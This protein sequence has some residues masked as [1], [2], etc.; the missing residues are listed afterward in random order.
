M[1]VLEPGQ[2]LGSYEVERLVGR[3]GMAEVYRATHVVLERQVAIKVLNRALNTDP[4]FPI[5]FLREAKAVAKLNHPHIVTI[6]DF[7][8]KGDLA[9]LVMELAEGGTLRE[10]AAHFTTLKDAIDSLLP[11][12]AALQY[13]HDR[14]IV[15]RDVKPINV[16]IDAAGRPLLADFG[17]ARV[18]AESLDT[19]LAGAGSPHYM[20]PEQALGAKVDHRADIYALGIV[21]YELIAGAPPYQGNTAHAIIHHHLTAPPPSLQAAVPAVPEILDA[22]IRRATSKQ[23]A[24]R[25][26]SAAEFAAL[27]QQAAAETPDLPVGVARARGAP[28]AFSATLSQEQA[29]TVAETVAHAGTAFFAR[30][31]GSLSA[32]SATRSPRSNR[33]AGPD[34]ALLN[35]TA[36]APGAATADLALDADAG[37]VTQQLRPTSAPQPLH[38]LALGLALVGLSV[39]VAAIVWLGAGGRT[40]AAGAPA[41]TL[42]ARL[43]DHRTAVRIA[44][45]GLD[46]ALGVVN[47]TLMRIAVLSDE[48]LAFGTYRRLRQTHRFIGYATAL[49]A[50]AV[51][52]LLWSAV[53]GDHVPALWGALALGSGSALLVLA[54]SKVAVVRYLASF[55]RYLP[56]I[57]VAVLTLLVVVF[58]ATLGTA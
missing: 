39:I 9:Y 10:N 48:E 21:T 37:A 2:R 17:L 13:A 24:E 49:T 25:F 34:R 15:H 55:R 56:Q 44:L 30:P 8:E 20:A 29:G 40:A 43:F 1:S 26:G 51:Q 36:L 57:G 58:L 18:L 28:D 14:G 5:R 19:R 54:V 35:N 11:V 42:A 22:A 3:G 27:L 6:Y 46:L 50:I 52:V 16:L 47:A 38:W 45:A 4:T 32:R 7:D 33:N 23:P 12:C 53:L 41:G 31:A